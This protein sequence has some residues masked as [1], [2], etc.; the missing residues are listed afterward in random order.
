MQGMLRQANGLAFSYR[1]RAGTG[2]Q[3]ANDLTREAVGCNA[4]LGGPTWDYT[5]PT[6]GP[7]M[8]ARLTFPP[9]VCQQVVTPGYRSM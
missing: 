4:G 3:K 2:L 5:L 6:S 8:K 9:L 7:H 1:E